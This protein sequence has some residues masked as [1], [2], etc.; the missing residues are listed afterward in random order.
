MFRTKKPL[1]TSAIALLLCISM[2]LGTTFAWFTDSA[3]SGNNLIQSGN[4]DVEMYWSDKLLAADSTEWKNADGEAIFTYDKWEPGYTEVRY[5]KVKNAG[6]LALQWRLFIEAEGAVGKLAEVIQVYYVNP[7]TSAADDLSDLTSVGVLTDVLATHKHTSG[8]LLPAGAT[9]T[10]H[11][12]GE[13]ILA[14]AFHMDENAGNEYQNQSV[15]D[16]FAVNLIATQYTYEN[17]AFGNKYDEN[18]QWPNNVVVAG[19]TASTAVDLDA[20]NKVITPVSFSSTNGK[21]GADVPAGVK[22][23]AGANELTLSV[24]DAANN[25]ANIV[26]DE[27]E[28]SMSID[29]HIEGVAEDNDVVIAVYLQ[30]LLPVGLNMGNYR[31]YHMEDGQPV[32]M[33]LLEAGATP[34]HND[35]TYDPATGDVVM[36]LK[37]F[38]VFSLV[39][40]KESKWEGNYDYYWYTYKAE[41]EDYIIANA[42]QLAAFGAI[43]GGMVNATTDKAKG[44]TEGIT[45]SDFR[46][47]FAGKTVKLVADINLNDA[48]DANDADKIFYPIGYWNSEGT[49]EKSNKAISSGFYAFEGTF[50]G[51]G[52]A[53]ANFYQNTWEMKGD[54]NWYA[55][56]DQHYRDGMGLFGKVYGGTVKNLIVANF[57]SDGEITT[58]GTI[59]AYADCGATFEN[60]AIFNCNPR[61]YNIGNGGIVGC[62]GW[63]ANNDHNDPVTFKNITVDNSNKI[64]AL[65]GSW[66]VA[67]GGIVGQYYPTSGQT[68]AIANKGISMENCHVAA[69]IDVYNDVC[70]NYQYYA[71]RYAGML[72][73]SVRENETI[74]GHVYPKMDGI[75][76][77]GCTVHFGDWNDY[78]YCELVANS[79]ASYTHDHQMSRLTQVEDLDSGSKKYLPLGKTDAPEN[80]VDIP[81]EGRYNYVVVTNKDDKGMWIHG[82]GPQFATCYHFV[83]GEQHFHDVEDTDNPEIY[84]DVNGV[85]TLKEDKQLIYREFNNLVTGYGWGVTSRGFANLNGVLNVEH[86]DLEESEDKFEKADNA[87]TTITIEKDAT[88]ATVK[89]GDLFKAIA[90]AAIDTDNVQVFVSPVL[91]NGFD[92]PVSGTYVANTTDWTQG[93]L[94][95]T[96]SGDA[97]I[98]ITDFNY[99]VTTTILVKVADNNESGDGGVA[100]GDF[101]GFE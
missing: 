4:L 53:I 52:N 9:S 43:V 2:L 89:I 97:I 10:E 90:G 19:N 6:S 40:S 7:I 94:T 57:S 18:A 50:D 11:T 25:N 73:G 65:W 16:G 100:D 14:V 48:E 92:L 17:D 15:G 96:G 20:N 60:I 39:A 42:D 21:I 87:K 34:V 78:Y 1:F 23:A 3:A 62:V 45:A 41:N 28:A 66:D 70:A 38:S 12:V 95:L 56:E 63:Y 37:S 24:S 72:I 64:S 76:T 55:P 29:V 33:T 59:A 26:V 54:H 8:I 30:K 46:D 68:N 98:S 83:N 49:Y 75:S 31:L 32:A 74:D 82:D 27:T 101:P 99:C 69:Q 91:N 5:I 58:T 80:W 22:L 84:E 67:C 61:V 71:Y 35:F 36:Y 47:S 85:Q 86:S 81:T 77:K 51:N 44:L 79:L 93:T 13:T 88:S